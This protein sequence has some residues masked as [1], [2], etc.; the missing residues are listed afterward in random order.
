MHQSTIRHLER[1]LKEK[2]S[3][4]TVNLAVAAYLS[5]QAILAAHPHV[6]ATNHDVKSDGSVIGKLDKVGGKAVATY[7]NQSTAVKS[8]KFRTEEGMQITQPTVWTHGSIMDD[9]DGSANPPIGGTNLNYIGTGGVIH[10]QQGDL[11]VAAAGYLPFNN[12]EALFVAERGRGAYRVG[13]SLEDDITSQRVELSS[14]PT[15][16]NTIIESGW[17]SPATL[18]VNVNM[19]RS[20]FY[21]A[22]GLPTAHDKVTG[23][24]FQAVSSVRDNRQVVL[25]IAPSH[26]A[27]FCYLLLQE[28]GA[29]IFC[30]D[31]KP[32]DENSQSYAMLSIA[33]SFNGDV[34]LVIER[35]GEAM[36]DYR[37]WSSEKV[38]LHRVCPE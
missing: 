5:G 29:Q 22:I 32:M 17:T 15:K 12:P 24:V 25:N 7:L 11:Q 19:L 30:Q 23:G 4:H 20:G 14:E 21:N 33:P 10:Q 35:F 27:D 38:T 13:T 31:G 2:F 1:T 8:C 36:R 28:A 9:L 26:Q 16:K 18:E 3:D 37:G 34:N 6:I